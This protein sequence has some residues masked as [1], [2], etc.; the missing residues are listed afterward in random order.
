L[1]S[2]VVFD[3][4][5]PTAQAGLGIVNTRV[6]AANTVAVTFINAT[7]SPITPTASEVYLLAWLR[8]DSTLTG[9]RT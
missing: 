1:A 7:A 8:P 5:K 2:D 4:T 6:S 9:V 3:I